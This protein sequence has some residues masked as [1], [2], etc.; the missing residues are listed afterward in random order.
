MVK[1]ICPHCGAEWWSADSAGVWICECG[2]EMG[3]EENEAGR[4]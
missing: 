4:E 3:P 1:R 2:A